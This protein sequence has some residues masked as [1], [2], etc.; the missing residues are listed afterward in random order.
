MNF[1]TIC[2]Y[3]E[4]VNAYQHGDKTINV[5]WKWFHCL[6]TK[7]CIHINGRCD[8]HP[9]PACTFKNENGEMVA[10]DEEN[11]SD[12]YKEKGLVSK[13]SNYECISPIFNNDSATTL[14]KEWKDK[15]YSPEYYGLNL[16]TFG[17]GTLVRILA[18]KC[19]GHEECWNGTDEADCGLSAIKTIFIGK[20]LLIDSTCYSLSKSIIFPSI[21]SK[22]VFCWF[23]FF[24]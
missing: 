22:S 17:K 6:Q 21:N 2:S 18:T 13:S 9:H 12:I 11:C 14:F 24:L 15:G 8:L 5:D 16:A 19:D 4:L 23:L 3:R 10:E 1:F 20:L 7:K